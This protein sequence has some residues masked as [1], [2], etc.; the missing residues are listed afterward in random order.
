MRL[1]V[2]SFSGLHSAL[3]GDRVAIE[4]IADPTTLFYFGCKRVYALDP[5]V[6]QMNDLTFMYEDETEARAAHAQ[7]LPI[8]L[9]AEED[10]RMICRKK[11]NSYTEL[12]FLLDKH[13]VKYKWENPGEFYRLDHHYNYPTA[14]KFVESMNAAKAIWR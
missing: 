5:W 1:V 11:K 9:K 12:R 2:L 10:R 14:V 3:R 13:K 7:V 8:L 6:E 4:T